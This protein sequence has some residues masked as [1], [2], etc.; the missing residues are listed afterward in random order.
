[1]IKLKQRTKKSPHKVRAKQNNKEVKSREHNIEEVT[2]NLFVS[3][4]PRIISRI[5]FASNEKN[6]A[7]HE[8][9]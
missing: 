3:D 8:L 7:S 1:M 9:F 6:C 4:M 2:T 5:G